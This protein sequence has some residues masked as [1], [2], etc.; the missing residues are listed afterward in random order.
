MDFD[1]QSGSLRF[2]G[3]LFATSSM[4]VFSKIVDSIRHDFVVF[5]LGF[6]MKVHQVLVLRPL[7]FKLKALVLSGFSRLP[8]DLFHQ[9]LMLGGLVIVS[10][11]KG[12]LASKVVED[13]RGGKVCCTIAAL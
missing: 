4:P 6:V 11:R 12:G 8:Y 3:T 13:L 9:V 2:V 5:T 10:H 7:L 1:T